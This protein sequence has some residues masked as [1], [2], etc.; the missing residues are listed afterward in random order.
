[1]AWPGAAL[2]IGE[3][4]LSFAHP[5]V[6]H[7]LGFLHRRVRRLALRLLLLRLLFLLR[8]AKVQVEVHVDVDGEEVVVTVIISGLLARGARCI[9]AVL[10]QRRV[11][12]SLRVVLERM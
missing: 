4:V 5:L 11:Q 12:E 10:G 6:A 3:F 1:M 9:S 7:T 8:H 2:V